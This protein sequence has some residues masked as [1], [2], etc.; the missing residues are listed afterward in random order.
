MRDLKESYAVRLRQ[1]PLLRKH[2]IRLASRICAGMI[3]FD[4]AA[5]HDLDYIEWLLGI[6]A[7]TGLFDGFPFWTEQTIYAA[8]AARVGAE[9]D[10]PGAVPGRPPRDDC[11]DTRRGDRPLRRVLAPFA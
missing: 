4:P 2:G 7:E 1:W 6:D 5:V 10:R 9:W 11:P 3:S 8:L